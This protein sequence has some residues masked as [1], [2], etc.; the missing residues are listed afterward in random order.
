MAENYDA[1]VRGGFNTEHATAAVVI[2]ALLFLVLVRRGFR[3]FS[4]GGVGVN[5]K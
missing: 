1:P 3:G 2:G 5:L 4:A